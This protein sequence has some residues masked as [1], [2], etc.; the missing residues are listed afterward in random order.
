LFNLKQTVPLNKLDLK[1]LTSEFVIL[2]HGFGN[3]IRALM[4]L[5]GQQEGHMSVKSH[6]TTIPK[7][8]FGYQSNLE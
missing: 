8:T 1:Q 4:L 6:A 2:C 5:V 3:E 7:F